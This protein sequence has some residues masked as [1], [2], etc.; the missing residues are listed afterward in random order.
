MLAVRIEEHFILPAPPF[1]SISETW[2][3]NGDSP[4]ATALVKAMRTS[5][6]LTVRNEHSW[7]GFRMLASTIDAASRRVP[8]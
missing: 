5:T 6:G 4:L 2:A 7:P 1:S 3:A 8:P